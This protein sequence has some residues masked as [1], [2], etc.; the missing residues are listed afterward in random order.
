MKE[1]RRTFAQDIVKYLDKPFEVGGSGENGFDCLGLLYLHLKE[2]GKEKNLITEIDGIDL[3]NYG[4]FYPNAT[5]EEIK[6]KLIKI[7][8]ANGEEIPLNK[9]VAGDVVIIKNDKG[10]YFPALYVGG[11]NFLS[12]FINAGVRVLRLCKEMEVV[13][14]R[15][16]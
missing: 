4:N 11:G 2:Q 3:T 6:E 1:Q 15:R 9:K 12:S 8:E 14:V 16:I 7:F 13:K 5:Q 10:D